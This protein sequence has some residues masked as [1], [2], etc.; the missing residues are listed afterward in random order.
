[1]SKSKLRME[2]IKMIRTRKRRTKREAMLRTM[3]EDPKSR[4]RILMNFSRTS[5]ESL[6]VLPWT[7]SKRIDL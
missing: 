5:L 6:M 4:G 2:I 1:L 7:I 3:T